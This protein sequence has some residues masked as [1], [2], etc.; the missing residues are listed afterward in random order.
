[1]NRTRT[2]APA[3]SV[4]AVATSLAFAAAARAATPVAGTYQSIDIDGS[5]SQFNAVPVA[6]SNA[7]DP[8]AASDPISL[9]ITNDSTNLYLSV[10]YATPVVPGYG[11]TAGLYLAVDSDNNPATGN[12]IYG[13]PL[14]GANLGFVNDYPF[15]QT[16]AYFNTYAGTFASATSSAAGTNILQQSPAVSTTTELI[17]IA[18]DTTQTD[19]TAGAFNGLDF[20]SSFTLEA[21][22]SPSSGDAVALGPVTYTLADDIA[23]PEPTSLALLG[24]GTLPLLNRGRRRAS[25]R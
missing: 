22:T 12:A 4:A 11:G 13:S 9:K 20:P 23:S 18:L 6:A 8:N 24:V 19:A 16:A 2:L 17:S 10:T 25:R 15:S 1:M 3:A 5:P 21:Y 7:V 14:I